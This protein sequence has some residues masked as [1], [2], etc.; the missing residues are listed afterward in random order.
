KELATLQKDTGT[1]YRME[2]P[3]GTVSGM[4]QFV[5]PS[6]IIHH[7]LNS[8][9]TIT[10][11]L[12][13]TRPNMQ[14]LPRADE[15]DEGNMKSRVKEMFTSRFGSEGRIVEVDYSALEV[16]ALAAISGDE[17]LMRMLTEG[18]DMHCYRLA[19]KLGED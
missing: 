10:A 1:Y 13:A 2:K 7:Q 5:E 9:A 15:D 8:C 12:S 3:N 17:N 18:I 14:N 11:R 16:V 4:L 19:A 6:S